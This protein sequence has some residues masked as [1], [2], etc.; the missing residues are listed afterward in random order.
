M[1]FNSYCSDCSYD[2]VYSKGTVHMCLTQATSKPLFSKVLLRYL[3][4][5]SGM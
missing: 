5:H 1:G 2:L 4:T 3:S